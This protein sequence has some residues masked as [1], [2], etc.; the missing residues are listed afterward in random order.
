MLGVRVVVTMVPGVVIDG[1]NVADM[2]IPVQR[3]LVGGAG[4]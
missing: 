3:V 4:N 1:D 2:M